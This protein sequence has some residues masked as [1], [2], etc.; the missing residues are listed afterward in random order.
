M[1]WI[2]AIDNPPIDDADVLCAFIGWDDLTF[3]AIYHYEPL[4]KKWYNSD[5]YIAENVTHWMPLPNNP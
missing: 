1:D 5:G 2:S 3:Q 4:E